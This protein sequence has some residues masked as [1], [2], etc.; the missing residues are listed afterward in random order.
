MID[1]INRLKLEKRNILVKN[2]LGEKYNISD[3]WGEEIWDY[4]KK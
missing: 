4:N 3:P 1:N 2:I